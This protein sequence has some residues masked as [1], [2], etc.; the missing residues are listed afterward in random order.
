MIHKY[1]IF[2]IIFVLLSGCGANRRIGVAEPETPS[3]DSAVR[4]D[5]D[6]A[7]AGET[8]IF[9]NR[10]YHY[11]SAQRHITHGD[12]ERAILD[13]QK[14]IDLDPDTAYLRRELAVFYLQQQNNSAAIGVL[15]A[16]VASHPDD[17]ESQFLYARALESL[18]RKEESIEA[19]EK[20][21]DRDPEQE[22]A[23]LRLGDLYLEKNDLDNAFR[24]YSKLLEH[25]PY[26]Y[27]GHFFIGK[28]YSFRKEYDLAE[29]HIRR[30]LDLVP[31]LEEPNYEL[32]EIYKIKEEHQKAIDIYRGILDQNPKNLFAALELAVLYLEKGFTTEAT[33]LLKNVG[34]ES[35]N[36]PALFR[37]IGQ[38][39]LEQNRFEAAGML[40]GEMLKSAPEGSGLSYLL[41]IA[42]VGSEDKAEAIERFKQV[43]E[44]SRFFIRSAIQIALLYQETGRTDLAIDHIKK[45]IEKDSNNSDL[46]LYLGMFYEEIELLAEASQTLQEGL[47]INPKH[48]QLHFRL[49]VVFDKLKQ[50]DQSIEQ[51][52]AVIQLDQQH[53]NALNYL[54]YTYADMGIHLDEAEKLIVTA[55]ELKPDDGYIT[56]SLGWVY[57]KKGLFDQALIYLE[58]AVQLVPDD[59]TILEHLGDVY[60]KL[61]QAQKALDLYQRSLSLKKEDTNGIE[62]KIRSLLENGSRPE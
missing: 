31:G 2:L 39:Y 14:V 32:A 49:G 22:M 12:L 61:N 16:L 1:F 59:P 56:D 52:K 6:E 51:M 9:Q 13:L 57:Y 3:D 62:S 10:Y 54:G 21:I 18:D 53:V 38:E 28:I 41:G 7:E 5:A 19:Y 20:L 26:S 4:G 40:L 11:L 15:D 29:Q 43:D 45:V 46:Y 60:L 27:A 30:T 36:D 37:I 33:A 17:S 25:F 44:S 48:I 24:V 50:R 58:K 8:E 42:L 35:Y 47:R 34:A 23:F 55:L